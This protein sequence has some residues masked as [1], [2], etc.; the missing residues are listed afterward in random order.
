MNN[1]TNMVISMCK[2]SLHHV[3]ET[4]YLCNLVHYYCRPIKKGH[5][6]I[7]IVLLWQKAY[8]DLDWTDQS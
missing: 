4:I 1:L 2:H 8:Y 3:N 5:V 6:E 7:I